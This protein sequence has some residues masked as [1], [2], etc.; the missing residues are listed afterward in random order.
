[1][2]KPKI[3]AEVTKSISPESDFSLPNEWGQDLLSQFLKVAHENTYYSANAM[4]SG[5]KRLRLA[6]EVFHSGKVAFSQYRSAKPIDDA[7]EFKYDL[8][9]PFF[10]ATESSLFAAANLAMSQQLIEAY[11]PLRSC[12]ETACYAFLMSQDPSKWDLWISRPLAEE[13]SKDTTGTK[14]KLRSKVGAE[15]GVANIV[16]QFPP[17]TTKLRRDISFFYDKMIDL[18]GHYNLPALQA[19][20]SYTT[21]AEVIVSFS[22]IGATQQEARVSLKHLFEVGVCC[23]RVLDLAFGTIWEPSGVS[24]EI[25]KLYALQAK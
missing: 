6:L 25:K 22:L 5:V 19:I 14:R 1:M 15:F 2:Q 3:L 13:V 21:G 17:N 24:A 12:L 11:K 8:A 7:S 16:K 18:G 20:G 23:L 9:A 4:K 10:I